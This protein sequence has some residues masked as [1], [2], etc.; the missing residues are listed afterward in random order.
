MSAFTDF[1]DNGKNMGGMP[2]EIGAEDITV[3]K[4]VES[5][6]FSRTEDCGTLRFGTPAYWTV[7]NILIDKGAEGIK[8]GLDK[9]PGN[10]CLMLGIWN[11]RENNVEGDI[12]DARVYRRVHLDKGRYY[13][14]GQFDALYQLYAGYIFVA[15]DVIPTSEMETKSVAYYNMMD[16]AID[17]NHYGVYFT[18]EESADVILGMQADMSQGGS[19]QEVRISHVMLLKYSEE[20][21]AIEDIVVKE[22][23]IS[24]PEFYSLQGIKLKS[25]PAKGLYIMRQNGK[26]A[27]LMAH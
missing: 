5:D 1:K 8:N 27:V 24:R 23:K 22:D 20:T 9:Y 18:L 14:G 10:D 12:A 2:D 3:E 21:D 7:E 25:A 13:F 4:L 15:E 6:N 19:A 17:R 11:D 26:A 16:G